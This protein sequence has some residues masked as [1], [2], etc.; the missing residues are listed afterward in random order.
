MGLHTSREEG[1]FLPFCKKLLFV[2]GKFV[3]RSHPNVTVDYRR[4]IFVVM[5]QL[6][7]HWT[8]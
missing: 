7:L 6:L 5:V 8:K 1:L 4:I 2:E 3:L